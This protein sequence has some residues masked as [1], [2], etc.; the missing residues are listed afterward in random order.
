MI[1]DDPEVSEIENKL[2]NR[3]LDIFKAAKGKEIG[4]DYFLFSCLEQM[5]TQRAFAGKSYGGKFPPLVEHA[6]MIEKA[7]EVAKEKTAELGEDSEQKVEPV[8]PSEIAGLT[9]NFESSFTQL[10]DWYKSE[11]SELSRTNAFDHAMVAEVIP[12][13]ALLMIDLE[14]LIREKGENNQIPDRINGGDADA[15]K[16]WDAVD[17]ALKALSPSFF[18]LIK[19]FL[20]WKYEKVSKAPLEVK[21][22]PPVGRFNKIL[23]KGRI[24]KRS[25]PRDKKGGPGGR[26]AGP[27]G[28][29]DGKPSRGGSKGGKFDKRDRPARSAGADRSRGNRP[30]RNKEKEQE[31]EKAVIKEAQSAMDKL[32]N[33]SDLTEVLLR[34]QNSFLR[35]IQHK[36]IVDAGFKSASVGEDDSRAVKVLKN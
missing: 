11:F 20:D 14:F 8:L 28:K 7:I 4:S 36:H 31:R 10:A 29:P 32:K 34:P 17:T 3:T 33:G 35:R 18:H 23:L 24:K 19:K 16:V 30:Q 6:K 2:E 5:N 26:N 21:S 27:R 12:T 25:N 22:I 13:F 15:K 1:M 9:D